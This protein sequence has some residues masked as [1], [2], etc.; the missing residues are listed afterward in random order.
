MMER[1]SYGKS[2][3]TAI[4][5]QRGMVEHA[6]HLPLHECKEI[7]HKLA[8]IQVLRV[9]DWPNIRSSFIQSLFSAERYPILAYGGGVNKRLQC[10]NW[11]PVV[12]DLLKPV[13]NSIHLFLSCSEFNSISVMWLKSS[14]LPH[15]H[16]ILNN[17]M[18]MWKFWLYW[19][20]KVPFA[21][22]SIVT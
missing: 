1:V 10:C 7:K 20:W 4:N 21:K 6:L 22:I 17:C 15:S 19:L 3:K 13:C 8:F 9:Q 5:L 16:W 12:T 18:I 2:T 14:P 11:N